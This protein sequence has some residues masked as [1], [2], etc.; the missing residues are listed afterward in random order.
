[1]QWSETAI[2]EARISRRVGRICHICRTSSAIDASGRWLNF[3][4]HFVHVVV[5]GDAVV[6]HVEGTLGATLKHDSGDI[7]SKVV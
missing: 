7:N 5:R 6:R 1:L 3:N 4:V 2:G